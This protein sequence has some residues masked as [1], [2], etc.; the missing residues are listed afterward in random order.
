MTL[1]VEEV[2]LSAMLRTM[3]LARLTKCLSTRVETQDKAVR[4]A[5]CRALLPAALLQTGGCAFLEITA[6][7]EALRVWWSEKVLMSKKRKV[8]Q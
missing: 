7:F 4:S 2:V 1:S 8:G 6:A 3:N 5:R